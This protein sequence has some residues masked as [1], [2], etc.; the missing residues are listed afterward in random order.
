MKLIFDSFQKLLIDAILDLFNVLCFTYFL[1]KRDFFSEADYIQNLENAEGKNI[2]KQENVQCQNNLL[3][4][5][6]IS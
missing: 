1:S 5:T 4:K 3:P 6:I 2:S